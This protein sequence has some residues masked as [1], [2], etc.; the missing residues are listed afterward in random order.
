[1]I[2]KSKNCP[3][4]SEKKALFMIRNITPAFRKQWKL[5]CAEQEIGMEEG[6]VLLMDAA[7]RG[8]IDFNRLHKD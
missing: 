2:T 1:M 4:V 6:I 5:F 7:I 8:E 3:K